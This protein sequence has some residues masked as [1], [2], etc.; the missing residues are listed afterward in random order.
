MAVS[1]LVTWERVHGIE[2][3]TAR[4]RASERAEVQKGAG[5]GLL[6]SPSSRVKVDGK[7]FRAGSDK[8]WVKGVTYGPFAPRPESGIQ[9]PPL[10][11][12]EAD[13]RLLRGLG[14]N[15]IR[16]YHVPPRELLDTAQAFGLK[17]LIDVPWSKHRCF[18]DD[19]ADRETGRTNV[20]AAARACREHSAVLAY[21]VVNE[22]PT[23][24]VR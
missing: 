24:V 1:G 9:L 21:S 5:T 18:L 7:F 23:D 2:H 22:V 8:F 3:H 14:A 10:H 19:A 20:R 15:T 11:Q 4:D 12:M 13:F 16:V 6:A 17:V